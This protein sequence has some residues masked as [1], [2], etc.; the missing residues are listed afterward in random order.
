MKMDLLQ[1]FLGWNLIIN[2]GVLLL[3]A[4]ILKFYPDFMHKMHSYWV[5]ISREAF[6]SIHYGGMGIY[7]LLIFV[8][9]MVPYFVLLIIK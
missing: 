3:W 2:W 1:S 9:I 4:F 8:F 7:K 5:P 6:N